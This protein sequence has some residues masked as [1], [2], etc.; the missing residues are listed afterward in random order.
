[1]IAKETIKR[2]AQLSDSAESTRTKETLV[3]KVINGIVIEGDE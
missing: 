2:H 3:Y 1:M